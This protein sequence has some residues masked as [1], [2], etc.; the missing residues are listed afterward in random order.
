M[1]VAARSLELPRSAPRLTVQVARDAAEIETSLALRHRV[2]VEE[3]GAHIPNQAPDIETDAFDRH[4]RHLLVRD[5]AT[6][7][8]L[9]ST[10]LLD[11][12]G[13]AAAGGFYSQTE[14]ELESML[15]LPGRTLEIGRTCVA[16]DARHGTVMAVLWSGIARLVR[17]E[18]HA[19]LIGCV[20]LDARDGGAR[21]RALYAAL[22]SRHRST[23]TVVRPRRPL[24]AAD[25]DPAGTRRPPL[26]RT[27][28]GLGA[29][30]AGEPCWDPAFRVADLFMHLQVANLCPRY[31][32]HFLE[33]SGPTAAR[34][35][36][37][38]S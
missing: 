1:A 19:H 12:A 37:P 11:D 15:E 21:A 30:V 35:G 3:M 31:A 10:R 38:V 14:F 27:Y 8:L 33:S 2:F 9:A 26:L 16:P 28:L 7:R 6:G 29:T 20:S 4:C 17:A 34:A 23:G 24:P 25:A 32:R 18:D 13:A 36:R 22:E 5:T